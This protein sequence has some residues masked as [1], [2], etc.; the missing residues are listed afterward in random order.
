MSP[1]RKKEFEQEAFADLKQRHKKGAEDMKQVIAVAEEIIGGKLS[2]IGHFR[3][4]SGSERKLS[5]AVDSW[6]GWCFDFMQGCDIVSDVISVTREEFNAQTLNQ[7]RIEE[8]REFK[9]FV[10]RTLAKH[11]WERSARRLKALLATLP[12]LKHICPVI[13][14]TG[15]QYDRALQLL[16]EY[17]LKHELIRV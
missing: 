17:E 11:S 16:D 4:T 13:L 6:E 7:S 8:V 2:G 12:Y 9:E 1:A 14:K 5:G 10:K 3:C 15:K